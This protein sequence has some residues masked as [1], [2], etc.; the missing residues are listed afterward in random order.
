MV[1]EAGG[2]ETLLGKHMIRKCVCNTTTSEW[3]EFLHY[4]RKWR[5]ELE[6]IVE[7]IREYSGKPMGR[8][9]RE[10]SG[11]DHECWEEGVFNLIGT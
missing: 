8:G 2:R 4:K 11:E 7:N 1:I 5:R 10:G 6:N 9:L 3:Y